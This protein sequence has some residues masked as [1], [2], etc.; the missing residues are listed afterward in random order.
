MQGS[1][2]QRSPGSWELQVFLGRDSNGKRRRVTE[3]V[4]GKRADAERRLREILSDLDHGIIPSKRVYKL[5]EW[6][7]QWMSDVVR[8]NRRQKTVDRY[9][10]IIRLHIVPDMGNME[11]SKIRPFHVQRLE[12]RL[13]AEEGMKPK[14]VQLVHT[15]LNGAM[16][17][18][19][20][21]ELLSKNP[22][23]SV[24]PPSVVKKEAY[25]PD[26][27]SVRRLLEI[28][29]EEG[30]PLWP[31]IHLIAY[32]G[33]R[34]G[35]A[36]ALEWSRVDLEKGLLTVAAS[37]VVT[38]TGV[39]LE[40]PKTESGRRVVDLDDRTVEIL[41]DHRRRQEEVAKSL[42]MPPPELVFPGNGLEGWCHPNTLMHTVERL[43]EK[44]GCQKITVRSL[45]HFHAT[46]S[47]DA[48][49]DVVVVS[50]RLGH[51]K[52]SIT[53][54][55]YAHVLPGWQKEVAEAFAREM[56]LEG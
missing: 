29:G 32:T 19:V 15:V 28:A 48:T 34:R 45:R 20:K 33:M 44:A 22:V 25:S 31:C 50:K 1:I 2:R 35:E 24:S 3:T 8:P 7:K 26:V 39:S 4:R 54:D 23:S 21:M 55:I 13:L 41:R 38:A 47:L 16:R 6:L 14:G 37:L 12:G 10:G 42:R 11:L 40:Q 36:M 5:D 27:E 30:H 52:V 43:S 9:S 51:S 56:D 18:A 49:K 46:V 17:H 53:L